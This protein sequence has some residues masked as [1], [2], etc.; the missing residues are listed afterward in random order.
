MYCIII[1]IALYCI[2]LYCIVIKC[3]ACVTQIQTDSYYLLLLFFSCLFRGY[4]HTGNTLSSIVFRRLIMFVCLF[5]YFDVSSKVCFSILFVL[6]CYI[7]VCFSFLF[8]C[9]IACV[10]ACSPIRSFFLSFVSSFPFC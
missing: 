2:I 5:L 6:L 1:V 7:V 9:F 10:L 4:F 8:C 3:K